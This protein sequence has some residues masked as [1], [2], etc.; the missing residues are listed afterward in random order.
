MAVWD[1]GCEREG[2]DVEVWLERLSPLRFY[3]SW[4]HLHDYSELFALSEGK[5][6]LTL[7]QLLFF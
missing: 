2:D 1:T 3:L 7:S 5:C 6:P 4:P